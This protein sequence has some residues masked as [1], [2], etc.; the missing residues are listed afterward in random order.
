MK[1]NKL[2]LSLGVFSLLSFLA[3]QCLFFGRGDSVGMMWIVLIFGGKNF[4]AIRLFG[5]IGSICVFVG[6]VFYVRSK[7]KQFM[8]MEL[9]ASVCLLIASILLFKSTSGDKTG[10]FEALSVFTI[11]VNALTG[12]SYYFYVPLFVTI[13]LSTIGLIKLHRPNVRPDKCG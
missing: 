10:S 1:T 7:S 6:Y 4:I 13:I 9:F 8:Q 2:C 5:W 12:T 11:F 3:F